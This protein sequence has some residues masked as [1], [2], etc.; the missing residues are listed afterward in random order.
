MAD[1]YSLTFV[2]GSGAPIA[3]SSWKAMLQMDSASLAFYFDGP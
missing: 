2:V 3:E 1:G